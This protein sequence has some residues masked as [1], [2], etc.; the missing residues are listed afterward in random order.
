MQL[1]KEL[2]L[3]GCSDSPDAFRTRLIDAMVTHFPG[4]TIDDLVCEPI[5]ALEYTTLIREAVSSESLADVVILK[6]LMNIRKKKSCPTGLKSHG[7]REK[8]TS[9]LLPFQWAG[10]A[11]S[12]RELTC[13]SFADMY[14]SR[15]IDNIVCH[16][17]EAMKL[18]NYVRKRGDNPS[19]TDHLILT[20]IMNVRKAG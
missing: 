5:S 7:T 2:A 19:L 20:T 1:K 14:K 13:D 18:C 16:P 17:R 3:C 6:T 9:K 10:T 8:L 4:L 11:K 12:F 15:T